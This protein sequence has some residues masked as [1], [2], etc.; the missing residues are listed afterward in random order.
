MKKTYK[1]NFDGDSGYE[2]RDAGPWRSY[3]ISFYGDTL[4]ECLEEATITEIDQ[5]GGELDC[6]GYEHAPFDAEKFIKEKIECKKV[7]I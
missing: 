7:K 4:E 6:Y 1:Y 2:H 5:D 3:E